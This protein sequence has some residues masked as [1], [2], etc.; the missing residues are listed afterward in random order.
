MLLTTVFCARFV[1]YANAS[2][3]WYCVHVR[4]IYISVYVLELQFDLYLQLLKISGCLHLSKSSAK[5]YIGYSNQIA[6]FS[7]LNH[8][9]SALVMTSGWMSIIWRHRHLACTTDPVALRNDICWQP[10]ALSWRMS[11]YG[12]L[13]ADWLTRCTKP[14]VWPLKALWLLRVPPTYALK[15][16]MC[17]VRL[18]Q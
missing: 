7:S 10:S 5:I 18:L 6:E 3:T 9:A 4:Y 12:E 8:I 15:N 11:G 2:K 17:F 16:C 1:S 13:H 14:M